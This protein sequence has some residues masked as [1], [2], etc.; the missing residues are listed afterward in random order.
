MVCRS[1]VASGGTVRLSINGA[2]IPAS[3]AYTLTGNDEFDAAQIASAT[4]VVDANSAG[5]LAAH[6]GAFSTGTVQ[7]IDH[8]NNATT[9]VGER[10]TTDAALTTAS[11]DTT[12]GGVPVWS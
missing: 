11:T 1:N 2:N 6:V 5:I 3:G 12:G 9:A 8:A 7:L 4:N 10:Y